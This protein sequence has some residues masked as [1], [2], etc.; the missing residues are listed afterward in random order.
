MKKE[1]EQE[2]QGPVGQTLIEGV[3]PSMWEEAGPGQKAD[4][5]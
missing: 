4:C 5:T 1:I 2:G 3:Q